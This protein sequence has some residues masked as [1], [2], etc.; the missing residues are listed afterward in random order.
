[1]HILKSEWPQG[2]TALL[3]L[4]LLEPTVTDVFVHDGQTG[5]TRQFAEPRKFGVRLIQLQASGGAAE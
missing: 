2:L 5:E 3:E 1:M 4:I